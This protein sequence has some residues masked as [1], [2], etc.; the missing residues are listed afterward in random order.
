DFPETARSVIIVLRDDL[1]SLTSRTMARFRIRIVNVGD[2]AE[3]LRRAYQVREDLIEHA[4]VW[5]DPEHPLEG[6]HRDTDGHA[7]LEFAA[8]NRATISDVLNRKHHSDY[9][10]LTAT[11]DPLG[12]PCQDCGNIAGPAQPPVCPNCGFLDIGRC[13]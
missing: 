5:V 9:T 10:V 1:R 3:Q 7:Y 4:R 12:E 8:E 11:E 2:R 6:V 13:P